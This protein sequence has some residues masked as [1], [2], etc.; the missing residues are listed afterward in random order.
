[1]K[2]DTP[3]SFGDSNL[4]LDLVKMREILSSK[5]E[6]RDP[7]IF[8]STADAEGKAPANPPPADDKGVDRRD[9]M[10]LMGGSMALAGLAGCTKHPEEKIVPYVDAPEEIIPGKP[11]FYASALSFGGFA[12]G[13][14]VESHMGRPTKV[15]GNPRHP[16]SL[17]GTDVFAQASVMDLYDPDRSKHPL[18]NGVPSTKKRMAEAIVSALDKCPNGLG[19]H[20]VLPASSSPTEQAMI[21]S[22]LESLPELKVHRHAPVGLDNTLAGTELA[23]GR[24]LQPTLR[25]EKADVIVALDADFLAWDAGKVRTARDFASRRRIVEGAKLNRLYAIESTMSQT[26]SLA[27]HRIAVTAK[28]VE[29]L[30]RHIAAGVGLAANTDVVLSA[31]EALLVT[32]I[33]KDLKAAGSH[34][35][36]VAGEQQPPLV[37]AIAAAINAALGGAG[38]TVEYIEPVLNGPTNAAE[39][40]DAFVASMHKGEVKAAFLLGVNPVYSSAGSLKFADALN[41]VD[42]TLHLGNHVDETAAHCDWHVPEVHAL[43][44]WSDT[45]AF[46]GTI[47]IAQPLIAPLYGGRSIIEILSIVAGEEKKA[48]MLVQEFWQANQN[49]TEDASG[50]KRFWR[51][52]LHEGLLKGTAAKPVRVSPQNIAELEKAFV[53]SDNRDGVELEVVFRPD[54][55]VWDGTSANNPWLQEM[56]AP[57]STLTW[58]TVITMSAATAKAFSVALKPQTNYK[59]E[60]EWDVQNR[61]VVNPQVD[62]MELTVGGRKIQGPV[63]VLPGHPDKSITVTFGGGRSVGKVGTGVGFNSFDLRSVGGSYIA[64]KAMLRYTGKKVDLALTQDHFPIMEDGRALVRQATLD[65]YKKQHSFATDFEHQWG[66]DVTLYSTSEWDYTKGQQWGM[67]VDLNTCVGCSACVV[68][69][70]AENN[71]PTVGKE[72][73]MNGREMHWIRVDRYFEKTREGNSKLAAGETRIHYQPM[74]CVHC[75]KAPCETVCPV[76]ATMHGNDGLNMMVYNRCVGTRYCSNNCPYKVRRYNYFKYTDDKTESLKLQRN[77]DVT[78]RLRGIMEK[79]TYCVQRI[80]TARIDAKVKT[81]DG[82]HGFVE[83]GKILTACQQVCPTQAITFGDQNDAHSK[84]HKLK[85]SDLNY[86]LLSGLNLTPRTTYLAKVRNMNDALETA[87]ELPAHHGGHGDSHGGDHGGK[88]DSHGHKADSHDNHTDANAH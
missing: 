9:F 27:D 67:V 47:T 32:E 69:C 38:E 21:D 20:L 56:P 64:Q 52:A 14:L 86:G 11:L 83:D 35:V 37:H 23:F 66:K 24:A 58:D 68:A 82:S 26:G 59:S 22:L 19:M 4:R 8:R 15:E 3:T 25:L 87:I 49:L 12:Q 71:I 29:A 70:Q 13:V 18:E 5:W 54:Y 85:Q 43:E 45:R 60:H 31:D 79:C 76:G 77:P 34:A 39:D 6:K 57:V 53:D 7:S 81:H 30:A 16:A 61:E 65:Q 1:M 41:K 55:R 63:L 73:V 44:T 51:T 17:G 2:P 74:A 46:D 80:N 33:I 48:Y 84:V 78:V 10:K 40:F 72:N 88:H 42:F 36:V 75:E 62:V 50:F 28:R